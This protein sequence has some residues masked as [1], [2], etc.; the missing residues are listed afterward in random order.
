MLNFTKWIYMNIFV[1]AALRNNTLP[2]AFKSGGILCYRSYASWK[3]L[4]FLGL[5]DI[6]FY[7]KMFS[8][9]ICA[10]THG[11]YTQS[12]IHFLKWFTWLF[13]FVP[14][15][16]MLLNTVKVASADNTDCGIFD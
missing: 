12:F 11:A 4:Y 8:F 7:V 16:F 15:R 14:L 3:A 1:S 13:L 10:L 2:S 5:L 9:V 6:Y